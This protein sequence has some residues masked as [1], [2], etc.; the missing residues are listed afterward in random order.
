MS[1]K[2]KYDSI[3]Q[4][5]T[6]TYGTDSNINK[7]LKNNSDTS[8]TNNLYPNLENNMNYNAYNDNGNNTGNR[9]NNHGGGGKYYQLNKIFY[10]LHR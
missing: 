6:E 9:Y 8:I 2:R 7:A 5:S 10:Q 1:H 3:H 4:S